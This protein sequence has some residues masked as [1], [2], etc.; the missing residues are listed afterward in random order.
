METVEISPEKLRAAYKNSSPEMK[1]FLE[2]TFGK[3]CFSEIA[4]AETGAEGNVETEEEGEDYEVRY[5]INK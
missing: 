3:K 1:G 2:F 4:E 5:E